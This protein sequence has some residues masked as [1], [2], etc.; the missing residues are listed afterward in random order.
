LIGHE[1]QIFLLDFFGAKGPNRNGIKVPPNR[2]LTAFPTY[3]G[4]TFL[5]YAIPPQ[6]LSDAKAAAAAAGKK[7][8][9]VGPLECVFNLLL[10]CF[11]ILQFF[12]CGISTVDLLHLR[13]T[14]LL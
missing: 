1:H 11:L 10:A 7:K 8:P 4:N 3:P 12:S 13:A 6:R 2:I 9:Q 14:Y 5:G